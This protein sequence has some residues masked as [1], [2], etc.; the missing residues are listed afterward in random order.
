MWA[1]AIDTQHRELRA[2]T[3]QADARG[4]FIIE[5]LTAGEYEVLVMAIGPGLSGRQTVTV[6]DGAD[7]NV[8]ITLVANAPNPGPGAE[9][10]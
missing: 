3:V 8:T 9:R 1:K 7:A 6:A 5:N 10:P 2:N 4:R